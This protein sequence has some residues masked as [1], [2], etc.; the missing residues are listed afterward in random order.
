[1]AIAVFCSDKDYNNQDF[2]FGEKDG[3]RQYDGTSIFAIDA[4]ELEL[5]YYV[6]V[7]EFYGEDYYILIFY[8]QLK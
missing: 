2:I 5:Y 8:Y 7:I 4:S 1:M 3:I 6:Q